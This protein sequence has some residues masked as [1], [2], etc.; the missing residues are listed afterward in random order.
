MSTGAKR[1]SSKFGFCLWL[2]SAVLLLA[3]LGAFAVSLAPT[4]AGPR[5]DD[6]GSEVVG[7]R[8]VPIGTYPWL[9]SIRFPKGAAGI[10]PNSHWCGGTLIAPDVVLSAAHCFA[11]GIPWK[12]SD[13]EVVAGRTALLRGTGEVRNVVEVSL[14]PRYDKVTNRF[15]VAV[16]RLE[17][18]IETIAPVRLVA[19]ASTRFQTPGKK[20]TVAGWGSTIGYPATDFYPPTFYPSRMREASVK[21][22]EGSVCRSLYAAENTPITPSQ[23]LCAAELGRDSCQGDSGGP[24]FADRLSRIVQVGIVSF[25][26]GCADPEFPGVYTRIA[27][28]EIYDFIQ[29]ELV[30]G[31][32]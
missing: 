26:S 28:P 6:M 15:D 9:V 19:R 21:L 1:Q 10:T 4:V 18:P 8:A 32:T 7:G 16:L 11:A 14:H 31:T 29:R 2:R 13:Y 23:Q 17:T 5:D 20:L 12:P 25:G 3:L 30:S 27:A 22:V 24:L